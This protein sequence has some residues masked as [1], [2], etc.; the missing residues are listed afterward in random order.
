MCKVPVSKR[1]FRSRH[2][3]RKSVSGEEIA[4]SST[5]HAPLWA[6]KQKKNARGRS[7][8]RANGP[9]PQSVP[10]VV[11]TASTGRGEDEEAT[12]TM[13]PLSAENGR[14]ESAISASSLLMA[15]MSSFKSIFDDEDDKDNGHKN[16]KLTRNQS[17][18]SIDSVEL[19]RVIGSNEA[20]E[21][22]EAS[23]SVHSSL[24][25]A[26]FNNS[27]LSDSLAPLSRR[28][29][30]NPPNTSQSCTRITTVQGEQQMN[31]FTQPKESET[32][33][34]GWQLNSSNPTMNVP[35]GQPIGNM[36][37]N[38]SMYSGPDHSMQGSPPD[39]FQ[40]ILHEFRE[41]RRG[42]AQGSSSST[43]P[44]PLA[45]EADDSNKHNEQ[46]LK[47]GRLDDLLGNDD[48]V[49]IETIDGSVADI[50]DVA[51]PNPL[52]VNCSAVNGFQPPT[53]IQQHTRQQSQQHPNGPFS[54]NNN[55]FG[56]VRFQSPTLSVDQLSMIQG[57][58]QAPMSQGNNQVLMSQE[59][60]QVSMGRGSDQTT[61]S[62][63]ALN[64]VAQIPNN[65]TFDG[66]TFIGANTMNSQVQSLSRGLPQQLLNNPLLTGNISS[67]MSSIRPQFSPTNIANC[68]DVGPTFNVER[69]FETTGNVAMN[70]N[71]N[72]PI[73]ALISNQSTNRASE[74]EVI[75]VTPSLVSEINQIR[76]I[77]RDVAEK[78]QHKN[79]KKK[80]E[81]PP[82]VQE[83][84]T[85][86]GMGFFS[87]LEDM[88]LTDVKGVTQT[89]KKKIIRKRKP[90]PD[91][92]K[93]VSMGFFSC[94]VEQEQKSAP[95][96]EPE[97]MPKRRLVE[98]N[99][100]A[101]P[102]QS[103]GSPSL[104]ALYNWA[105]T[106]DERARFAMEYSLPIVVPGVAVLSQYS[107]Y[108][109]WYCLLLPIFHTLETMLTDFGPK[110]SNYHLK[111]AFITPT[112]HLWMDLMLLH[113]ICMAMFI[114]PSCYG[115]H[116]YHH[117]A[118]LLVLEFIYW[119]VAYKDI[120]IRNMSKMKSV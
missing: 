10:L 24:F 11:T 90:K 119:A 2:S 55:T 71:T 54:M 47:Q 37:P 102:Q 28:T 5:V 12:E 99:Q 16:G 27:L 93:N 74:P 38:L 31:Q 40:E 18:A 17:I 109:F 59:N 20:N 63:L 72:S 115:P 51:E 23:G 79:R 19:M 60:Y 97:V 117:G 61:M 76:V 70:S 68:E 88:G 49:S 81:D 82:P 34:S 83:K 42:D 13:I 62:Q 111:C 6:E 29:S 26:S 3:H 78:S 96:H 8:E 107:S 1:N 50:F 69:S 57:S 14:R 95:E 73:S 118:V 66:Y 67:C 92:L 116:A 106:V 80:K 33:V 108:A 64:Q 113:P 110:A 15:S 105:P 94:Q 84:V 7:L 32:E 30:F 86:V 22:H 114:W 46:T 104:S 41:K 120:V 77:S 4:V 9:D 44:P 98:T 25:D 48:D 53:K 75:G 36:F 52:A 21:V 100:L 85:L 65:V 89:K 101:H 91:L 43:L 35:T 45:P 58:N 87:Q 56:N 112:M 39:L 103:D